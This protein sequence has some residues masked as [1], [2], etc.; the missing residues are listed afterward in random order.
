MN[1]HFETTE[2]GK[3]EFSQYGK[4]EPVLII[5]GGHSNCKETLTHKGLNPQEFRIITPSRPGYGKTPLNDSKPPEQAA[6]LIACLLA[7]LGDVHKLIS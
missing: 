5:H 6:E 1:C 7:G 3:I 4:D 2:K